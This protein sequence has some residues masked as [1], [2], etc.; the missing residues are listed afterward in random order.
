MSLH[1]LEIILLLDNS[2]VSVGLKTSH[3]PVRRPLL[4]IPL[5]SL[6]TDNLNYLHRRLQAFKVS[7]LWKIQSRNKRKSCD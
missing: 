2:K 1:R 6:S 3:G 4:A 5:L 7:L